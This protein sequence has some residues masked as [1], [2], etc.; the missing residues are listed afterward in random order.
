MSFGFTF[1]AK[2]TCAEIDGNPRHD[3]RLSTRRRWAAG[4]RCRIR[5][6]LSRLSLAG[7]RRLRGCRR[8]LRDLGIPHHDQHP[9][10]A[11]DRDLHDSWL[12]RPADPPH[13]SG[14][15]HRARS[16]LRARMGVTLR[17]GI[18]TTRQARGRR[19]VL[20]LESVLV[21]R[22]GLLRHCLGGQA[23]RPLV[24]ARHR[25]AV[26]HRVAARPL[27]P[28]PIR[29]ADRSERRCRHRG[30]SARLVPT[31]S[32][33]TRLGWW[34]LLTHQSLLGAAH[35]STARRRLVRTRI[36]VVLPALGIDEHSS[37]DARHGPRR[38]S[39]V[40]SRRKQ[41]LPGLERSR[42]HGRCGAPHRHRT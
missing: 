19:S 26:L 31:R 9:R 13:L 20:R 22:I 27:G 2:L 8:L 23:S 5:R 4:H 21:G 10:W 15:R 42:T 17:Q 24:V 33:R 6:H 35:R 25:G 40:H 16:D 18:R 14:P 28:V 39:D 34:L 1:V 30:S 32:L 3:A 11:L 37:R 41:L 7:S 38:R 12:L 29:S 36:D